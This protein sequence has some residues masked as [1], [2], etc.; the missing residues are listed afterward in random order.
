M[1]RIEL[2]VVGQSRLLETYSVQT[3]QFMRRT[4]PFPAG[5]AGLERLL[6]ENTAKEVR[7]DALVI[8][9]AAAPMASN[10][11]LP[12]LLA[13][14]RK[15][16][17]EFLLRIDGVPLGVAIPYDRVEPIRRRRIVR[18]Q[19]AAV[20]VLE[21]W[22][23]GGNL[24]AAL[25]KAHPEAEFERLLRDLLFLYADETKVLGEAV[26]LP[27]PLVPLR[28]LIV[29]TLHAAM[30]EIARQMSREWASGMRKPAHP[31]AHRRGTRF[32]LK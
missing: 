17:S 15:I 23:S 6:A 18:L 5:F 21:S 26:R 28:K 7:K 9:S 30:Y 22:R 3:T 13:A 16:D 2:L 20:K 4:L 10:A 14:S 12:A 31:V 25:Q 24:R 29:D 11:A 32:L 1:N 27:W 19:S 8:A